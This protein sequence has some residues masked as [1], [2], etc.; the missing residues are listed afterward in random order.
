MTRELMMT[1]QLDET[2]DLEAVLASDRERLKTMVQPPMVYAQVK[3]LFTLVAGDV[4]GDEGGGGGE[5]P[6]SGSDCIELAR[7]ELEKDSASSIY[8]ESATSEDE[9]EGDSPT[10]S[11]TAVRMKL[12]RRRARLQKL[13]IFFEAEAPFPL[14][15]TPRLGL[16]SVGRETWRSSGGPSGNRRRMGGK[17]TG[18]SLA[19]SGA[20]PG[21]SCGGLIDL[22]QWTQEQDSC[23]GAVSGSSLRSRGSR[24]VSSSSQSGGSKTNS[25]G[26]EDSCGGGGQQQSSSGGKTGSAGSFLEKQTMDRIL[27]KEQEGKVEPGDERMNMSAASQADNTAL[28]MS[29][30]SEMNISAD[31]AQPEE[32]AAVAGPAQ[33]PDKRPRPESDK[34]GN[35]DSSL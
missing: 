15:D 22:D 25:S 10:E 8:E 3:E 26:T 16:S 20:S 11:D 5:D 31:S 27:E 12:D 28:N 24:K 19:S 4:E 18:G 32:T 30:V 6:G 7:L 13:N 1:Y 23:S 14:P 9:E 17:G 35:S 33:R 21:A 34:S 29:A 2:L